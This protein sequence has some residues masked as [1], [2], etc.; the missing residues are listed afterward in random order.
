MAKTNVV[1]PRIR[2]ARPHERSY[3]LV[4]Q[5]YNAISVGPARHIQVTEDDSQ[6][7]RSRSVNLG[8]D[9]IH[10]RLNALEDKVTQAIVAQNVVMKEQQKVTEAINHQQQMT[11]AL[12]DKAFQNREEFLNNLSHIQG[13]RLEE[14]TRILLQ[15]HIKYITSIVKRLNA[16]IEVSH[17]TFQGIKRF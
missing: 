6:V 7:R 13:E 5:D 15:D 9:S 1:F 3:D 8:D 12:I 16:D 14:N 17:L 11:Q 10:P 4:E 2:G